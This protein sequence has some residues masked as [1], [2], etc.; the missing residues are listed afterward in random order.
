MGRENRRN[1]EAES[2]LYVR[3]I[4]RMLINS[5]NRKKE[6]GV[7]TALGGSSNSSDVSKRRDFYTYAGFVSGGGGDGS[8][9]TSGSGTCAA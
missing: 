1:R 4:D 2:A 9:E 3:G 5:S 7:L 8:T 6:E